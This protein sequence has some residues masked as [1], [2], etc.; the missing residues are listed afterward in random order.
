M[1]TCVPDSGVLAESGCVWLNLAVTTIFQVHMHRCACTSVWTDLTMLAR[2]CGQTDLQMG[3]LGGGAAGVM[4]RIA[5]LVEEG[6]P[7][8]EMQVGSH[9]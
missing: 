7:Y 5:E 4:A 6:A 1:D 9:R 8:F 2:R 3:V